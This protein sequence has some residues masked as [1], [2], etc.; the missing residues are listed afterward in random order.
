MNVDVVVI[1]AGLAG[2]A[3][4]REAAANG[5]TVAVL[6]ARDRIGGRV[7]TTHD[8][9]HTHPIEFGAEWIGNSGPV[10]EL[11]E[12]HG[13]SLFH[14][15]G[16]HWIRTPHGVQQMDELEDVTGPIL[17]RLRALVS[18]RPDDLS[19]R[20][21]LELCCADVSQND[22]RT[23]TGY[24]EGFH[25]AD[26]SL[27]STRW[28]LEVESSQ[29]ADASMIRCDDGNRLIAES[30]ARSLGLRVSLLLGHVV[31]QVRWSRG[32]VTVEAR[33]ADGSM[34]VR[35]RKVIVTVPL[36]LLAAPPDEQGAI[37]FDPPLHRLHDALSTMQTGHVMRLTFVF[38]H[39]FWMDSEELRDLLFVQKFDERVP[40]FW[41]G[42]P[43][44][45]PVLIGWAAGPQARQLDGVRGVA[46]RDLALASLSATLGVSSELVDRELVSWHFHDWSADPFARGAYSYAGVGGGDA[47]QTLSQPIDDTVWI[48]GE[49]AAGGGRNATMDGAMESGTAAGR[50]V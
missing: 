37:A 3:A 18:R 28:L 19:L 38:R 35:A 8:R 48:A 1:G 39:A 2:L 41:R 22:R 26:P 14:A 46:L 21:A 17:D 44:G 30:I 9:G 31:T 43:L 12:A 4:A 40:T 10:R 11:L 36:A 32:N 47:W 5:H 33:N 45:A 34:S 7:W 20:E 15:D 49:G 6:E 16:N 23:F 24:I 13:A 27:V 50:A 25:A 42:D 29:S